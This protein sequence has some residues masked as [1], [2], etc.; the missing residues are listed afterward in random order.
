MNQSPM[1]FTVIFTRTISV[2]QEGIGVDAVVIETANTAATAIDNLGAI[3]TGED[4]AN[5]DVTELLNEITLFNQG[6]GVALQ[7][8]GQITITLDDN[9]DGAGNTPTTAN[10]MTLEICGLVNDPVNFSAADIAV[11]ITAGA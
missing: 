11:S 2:Q 6:E 9:I 5:A 8:G 1:S 7:A 3:D 4:T 10:A